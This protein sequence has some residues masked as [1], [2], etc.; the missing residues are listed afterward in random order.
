[1]RVLKFK[2][3]LYDKYD[4]Y[5]KELTCVEKCSIDYNSLTRLKMSASMTIGEDRDIDYFNDRIQIICSL[6]GEEYPLGVFLI[7]GPSRLLNTRITRNLTLYS[8]LHILEDDKVMERY[9]V[10]QGT[11]VVNECRRMLGD[12]KVR[13][14]ESNKT[15]GSD[16]EW[17]VGTE[18]IEIIN[19]LLSSINYTSLRVDGDGYFAAQPYILPTDR[20]IEFIY[21][22][23][24]DGILAGGMEDEID[25]FSVPNTI[26]R[27]TNNGEVVPPLRAVYENNNADS[28][29]SIINRGRRIV[30]AAEVSDVSDYET[31]FAVCKKAAYE[32]TDKYSHIN[33]QTAINPRHGYMNCIRL[34]S[35]DINDKYIET[36]WSMDCAVGGKMKHVCRKVVNI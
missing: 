36:S 28:P 33:F 3:L 34:R 21:E 5:K 19:D 26:I 10:A 24:I 9:F 6:N 29:V 2:Y 18:K 7:S 27:Y 16:R 4:N 20:E 22:P 1:M 8:K 32:L 31:L 35:G 14:P 30:D 12:Y 25:L 13:I 23:G 17:E 11:N 15:T